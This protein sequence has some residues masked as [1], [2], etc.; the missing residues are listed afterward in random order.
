MDG[1]I[2]SFANEELL[3]VGLS[4]GDLMKEETSY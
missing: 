3:E 1:D 4:D 2:C